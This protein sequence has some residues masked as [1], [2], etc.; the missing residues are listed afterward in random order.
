M[1]V[2]AKLSLD[3]PLMHI[4]QMNRDDSLIKKKKE[5]KNSETPLGLQSDSNPSTS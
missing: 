2:P 4:L 1:A 5:E 3:L